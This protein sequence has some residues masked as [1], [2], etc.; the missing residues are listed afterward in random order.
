[1]TNGSHQKA[2]LDRIAASHQVDPECLSM[3]DKGAVF[4][5]SGNEL[6]CLC[7]QGSHY[8]NEIE[9]EVLTAHAIERAARREGKHGT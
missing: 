6:L 8:W 1:M 3:G 5:R 7:Q 2:V 4:Y 9:A